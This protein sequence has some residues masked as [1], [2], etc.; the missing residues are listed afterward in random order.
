MND[1]FSWLRDIFEYVLL[2]GM[3]F[4]V[5]VYAFIWIHPLKRWLSEYNHAVINFL[6]GPGS[7]D[8]T[9]AT[10][11]V[12][13]AFCLFLVGIVT[14]VVG[15]WFV[16]PA[17]N[18]D[19]IY[20]YRSLDPPLDLASTCQTDKRACDCPEGGPASSILGRML[21]ELKYLGILLSRSESNCARLAYSTTLN[22]EA[23][24]RTLARESAEDALGGLIKQIRLSR[25]AAVCALGITLLAILKMGGAALV[26]RM[27]K[28]RHQGRLGWL[29]LY[30]IL[31]VPEPAAVDASLPESLTRRVRFWYLQRDIEPPRPAVDASKPE[32]G[33]EAASS[34]EVTA[35]D[36]SK[37]AGEYF[38]VYA[39]TAFMG[40]CLFLFTFMG[41]MGAEHEFHGVVHFGAMAARE[42]AAGEEFHG[43]FKFG[44]QSADDKA[45]GGTPDPTTKPEEPTSKAPG[46][47]QH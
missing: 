25:G 21:R 44:M 6:F 22:D 7:L 4:A 46:P 26:R 31:I 43:T 18:E 17:H 13:F 28:K 45:K 37:K 39:V 38:G 42:K 27:A 41:W 29:K 9:R 47:T 23:S 24:W 1:I 11:I 12:M 30:R 36:A 35:E 15:Y 10:G 34:K 40:L 5:L 16:E 20:F 14:N 33:V 32:S 2:G 3:A 8:I 19:L